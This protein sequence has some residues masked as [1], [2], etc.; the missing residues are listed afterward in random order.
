M[1]MCKVVNK[2]LILSERSLEGP[3]FPFC[4]STQLWF[5][6]AAPPFPS[7]LILWEYS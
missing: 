3:D 7:Y 5:M 1:D 4:M 2:G 6:M